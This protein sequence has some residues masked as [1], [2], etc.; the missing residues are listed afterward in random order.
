MP[1]EVLDFFNKLLGEENIKKEIYCVD[2]REDWEDYRIIF[3][4]RTHAEL[5]QKLIDTIIANPTHGDTRREVLFLINHAPEFEEW[6]DDE[7]A[8]SKSSGDRGGATFAED[9]DDKFSDLC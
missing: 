6:E 5:R 7:G 3:E 9:D 2:Y 4:D 8:G 1:Q